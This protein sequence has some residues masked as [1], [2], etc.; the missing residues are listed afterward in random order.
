MS[1]ENVSVSIQRDIA[2]AS[3]LYCF[4]AWAWLADSGVVVSLTSYAGFGTA[5]NAGPA[6]G[7]I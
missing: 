1:I 6:D 4:G 5:G 2:S 3:L 7:G